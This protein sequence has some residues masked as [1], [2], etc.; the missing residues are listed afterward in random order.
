MAALKDL[1]ESLSTAV[2]GGLIIRVIVS[3]AVESVYV[4]VCV[5]VLAPFD[6]TK[7]LTLVFVAPP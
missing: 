2:W 3:S 4:C 7:T 6:S 5:C 1:T